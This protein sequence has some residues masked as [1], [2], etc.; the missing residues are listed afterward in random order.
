MPITIDPDLETLLCRSVLNAPDA[1]WPFEP[2]LG[3]QLIS[4]LE[5][6]LHPLQAAARS[7]ALLT[8]PTCR[9]ALARILRGSAVELPV[10]SFLEVPD[11]KAVDIVATIGGN[12]QLVAPATDKEG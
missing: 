4:S 2:E 9:A 3:R 7:C 5:H 12:S 8:S 1:S 11:G 6:A 10:L